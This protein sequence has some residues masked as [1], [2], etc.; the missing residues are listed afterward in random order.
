[1][2]NFNELNILPC[3]SESL[4][5]LGI[6]QP[7]PIQKE[8]IP[9]SL[10]GKDVLA[11]AQTGTGKTIAYL[12]PV[13]THLINNQ[14]SQSLILAPTREL[15]LQIMQAAHSILR[16]S[17]QKINTTLLI[18]GEKF[19]RQF[20]QLK[21][22][23]RLIIGTPGRINDHLNRKS[24]NL[25]NT[26]ILVLDETDR[27]LDMGFS[28]QLD[29]IKSYMPEVHQTL[30][31]SATL[32]SNI[33]K[34][35]EKY[36]NNPVRIEVGQTNTPVAK[37]KQDFVHANTKEK[38]PLL[39]KE[40]S[41]RNGSVIVFVKTKRFADELADM[42]KQEDHQVNAIHGD[43][44]QDRRNRVIS[45]FKGSK[46]RILVATD[47]ASR[48]LD[49]PHVEH[50]INFDL[51]MQAEDYIHRIGRTARA[52]AE[53]NAL[54]FISKDDSIRLRDIKKLIDPDSQDK[55]FTSSKRKSSSNKR[56]GFFPKRSKPYG[57]RAKV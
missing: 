32:P 36:L 40:L 48:G 56:H 41:N 27:M 28:E 29:E 30:M 43:L 34:L 50:V 13:F 17:Q 19:F 7:T 3:L 22:K 42:L 12:I 51:P 52:G 31:F 33:Q 45:G 2:E 53:G 6:T 5:S 9:Q 16:Y 1:M 38:F 20:E 24:L 10:E 47:V 49:V 37:I 35:S 39:L 25:G 15:A 44:S 26:E 8:A 14:K 57:F 23:P 4:T 54:S 21:R 18:G 11:S 46:Y 55:T